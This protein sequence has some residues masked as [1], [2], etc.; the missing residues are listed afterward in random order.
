MRIL[1]NPKTERYAYLKELVLGSAFPWNWTV[2]TTPGQEKE[3]YDNISQYT[4]AFL[5]APG[6]SPHQYP[7]PNSDLT[8][9]CIGIFQE[10]LRHNGV[11][12]KVF[13]RA[14]A[15]SVH[16]TDRNLPCVPHVDHDELEHTN[17]LVYLTDA[18]GGYVT[19]GNDTHMPRE[20]DV[21]VFQGEHFF[22][23][24]SK[25]RRVCLV[26]TFL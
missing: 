24:P 19:C 26:G 17:I 5:V 3:G 11:E 6:N 8:N 15:N 13:Y 2:E 16:P 7:I 25:E 1:E 4:H 10:I 22:Q 14:S 18:H 12:P 9:N 20:D 23:P 21:I